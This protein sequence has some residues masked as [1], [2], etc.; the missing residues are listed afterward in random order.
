[1]TRYDAILFAVSLLGAFN[2]LVLASLWL[3]PD[4]R[5]SLP[6]IWP[7]PVVAVLSATVIMVIGG[8]HSGA[9]P[10]MPVL[11][12]VLSAFAAPLMLDAV[13]RGVGQNPLIWPY[14]L[15]PVLMVVAA[16][17]AEVTGGPG[18]RLLMFAQWVFTGIATLTWLRATGVQPARR[19]ALYLVLAFSFVHIAQLLRVTIPAV[20]RDIVPIALALAFLLLVTGLLLRSRALGP[21]F[22]NLANSELG[23]VA[24]F[25]L[26]KWL[27]DSKAYRSPDLRLADAA[28]ALDV[29][30]GELS[31]WLN[32]RGQTFSALISHKRLDAA[33]AMLKSEAEQS[34]SIEAVGLLCGF[35]S[36]SGFYKA[37]KQ[38]RGETPAAFRQRTTA[39]KLSTQT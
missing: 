19:A 24:I 32:D 30:A 35:N 33:E 3:A 23:D 29:S 36:R 9:L 13:R 1:M 8:A 25:R 11:E 16:V 18:L 31:R 15:A 6:Q 34:T 28:Q 4:R 22:R 14:L 20:F 39:D 38:R 21:W 5:S 26:R 10:D 27:D 2:A 12:W 37:F 7:Y 17:Y